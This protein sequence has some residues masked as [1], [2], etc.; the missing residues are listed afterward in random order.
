MPEVC[1]YTR[2]QATIS[3]FVLSVSHVSRNQGQDCN[4]DVLI[5]RPWIFVVEPTGST[6]LCIF[7]RLYLV[8]QLKLVYQGQYNLR[9]L[10]EDIVY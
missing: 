5:A 4:V 2:L 10:F 9:Q 8:D 1:I 3:D 7:R 6:L